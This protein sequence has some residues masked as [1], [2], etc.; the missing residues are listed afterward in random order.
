MNYMVDY[1][2]LMKQRWKGL[3]ET[4]CEMAVGPFSNDKQIAEKII[5]MC[6]TRA[7]RDNAYETP[8]EIEEYVIFKIIEHKMGV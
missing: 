1:S 7:I 3:A 2:E 5:K 6:Q 4:F 8:K